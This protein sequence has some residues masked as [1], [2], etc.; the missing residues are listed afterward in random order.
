[1]AAPERILLRSSNENSQVY[2]SSYVTRSLMLL[3]REIGPGHRYGVM[4]DDFQTSESLT[5]G[6]QQ[7]DDTQ[8]RALPQSSDDDSQ[9]TVAEQE[10]RTLSLIRSDDASGSLSDTIQDDLQGN[11]SLHPT[12]PEPHPQ[13]LSQRD[14]RSKFILDSVVKST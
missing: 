10:D 14:F 11:D 1:M 3:N 13:P 9:P 6:D 2:Q 4:T 8:Q 7:Q 12:F 5:D